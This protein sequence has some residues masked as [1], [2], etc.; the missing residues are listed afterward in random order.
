M[1]ARRRRLTDANVAKLAP[2]AREYTVGDTRLAGLGVRVRPSGHRSY[3]YCW[4]GEGGSR[5]ITLGPAA[6]MGVE[7]AR[8][9][10]LEMETTARSNGT[11][12]GAVPTFEDFCAGPV[13]ARFDIHK[14]STRKSAGRVLAG[15]LL[16]AFGP[17]PLDRIDH[18]GVHR[19]FDEYSQ[20]A[21]GGGQQRAEAASQHTQPCGRLRASRHQPG[22][23]HQ[24]QSPSDAHPLPLAR[25]NPPPSP[26]AGSAHRCAA[27]AR[28]AGG[29]RPPAPAHRLSQERDPDHALAGR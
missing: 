27:V 9:K 1:A 21:P 13:R 12:R 16:P 6:L 23:G 5:R 26:R 18:A 24:T 2:A 17:L 29:H 3:V 8:A 14:P 20:T 11:E 7:E 4:K 22:Q 25:G 15:K 28:A 19:W 10:C